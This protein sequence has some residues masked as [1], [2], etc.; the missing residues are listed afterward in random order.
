MTLHDLP[1][2]NAC[3]N[4][5]SAVLLAAGFACIRRRRI[6]AHRACMVG[7]FGTSCLFLVSYLT[8]H[9]QAGTTRFTGQGWIRPLY[10]AILGSHTVLAAVIV[11]LVLLTLRRALRRDFI[12]HARLA[13]WTLPLWLYVSVTGVVVYVLLYQVAPVR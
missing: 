6:A 5:A 3:L 11:P 7:A 12:R 10:F 1:A 8:Y 13:R 2:L 4:S 9:S